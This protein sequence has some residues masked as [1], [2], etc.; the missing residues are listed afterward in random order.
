M[1]YIDD[2]GTLPRI[3]RNPNTFVSFLIT[4]AWPFFEQERG[5]APPFAVRVV[6]RHPDPRI[7]PHVYVS[8]QTFGAPQEILRDAESGDWVDFPQSV[9]EKI[10]TA[11][12]A[13]APAQ[14]PA[15]QVRTHD[16]GRI[17]KDRA[18]TICEGG[19][20]PPGEVCDFNATIWLDT[21]LMAG[22]SS[23]QRLAISETPW[24]EYFNPDAMLLK[25]KS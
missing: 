3:F 8:V 23:H 6:L 14:I 10:V 11:F 20:R 13:F 7:L 16:G 17:T 24:I 5:D 9:L 25:Y 4:D 12:T 19:K 1:S 15:P 22:I 2:R 18:H 21:D